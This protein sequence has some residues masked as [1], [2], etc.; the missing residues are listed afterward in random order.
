MTE[1]NGDVTI[2]SEDL[3][4]ELELRLTSFTQSNPLP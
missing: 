3:T 1:E 2:A 4:T